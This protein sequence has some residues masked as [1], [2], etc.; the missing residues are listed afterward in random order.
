VWLARLATLYIDTESVR[1]TL[2]L[3]LSEQ[4]RIKGKYSNKKHHI[5]RSVKL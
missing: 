2:V 1:K 5:P 3:S 4:N